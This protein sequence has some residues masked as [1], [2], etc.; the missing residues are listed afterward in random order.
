MVDSC[1]CQQCGSVKTVRQSGK[2]RLVCQAC[3][4]VE[5]PEVINVEKAFK[6]GDRNGKIK[7][8]K[9]KPPQNSI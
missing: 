4:D 5:N 8:L 1:T 2:G 9:A 3:Y 7:T 6:I